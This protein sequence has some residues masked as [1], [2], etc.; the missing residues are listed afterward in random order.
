[1]FSPF[2][3]PITFLRVVRAL[4]RCYYSPKTIAFASKTLCSAACASLAADLASASLT[5]ASASAA[6]AA[7]ALLNEQDKKGF[8]FLETIKK[9]QFHGEGKK[10]S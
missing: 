5:R 2:S 9:M 4:C 1:M 3:T 10:L 8:L 6:A 7:F